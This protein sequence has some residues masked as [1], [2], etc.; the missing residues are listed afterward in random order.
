MNMKIGTKWQT[1]NGDAGHLVCVLGNSNLKENPGLRGMNNLK[2]RAQLQMLLHLCRKVATQKQLSAPNT[3]HLFLF[4]IIFQLT[5]CN[6]DARTVPTFEQKKP[7]TTERARGRAL[8]IQKCMRN[9]TQ[10]PSVI[11]APDKASAD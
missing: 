4:H 11:A 5:C 6:A 8:L 1:H 2:Y 3:K 7:K 10:R 9:Q